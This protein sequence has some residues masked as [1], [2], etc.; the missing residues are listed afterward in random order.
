MKKFALLTITLFS[1]FLISGFTVE[2]TAQNK[3][4]GVK[5]CAPCHKGE[6]GGMIHENWL[7]TKHADAYKT[8]LNEQSKEIAKKLGLKKPPHEADECLMCHAT[9]Y[10]KGEQRMP[11]NKKEDGVTCEAC[12]GAGS[13]YRTSHGKGKKEEGIKKG[14]VRGTNDPKRCTNCHNSD[15]PTYKGFNYKKDWE[16]I[17]H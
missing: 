11:S 7:K 1:L 10:F 9:G 12:H 3:F 14:L 8:L 16:K 15:S 4:V 5:S 17:K 6:K 13:A 2:I